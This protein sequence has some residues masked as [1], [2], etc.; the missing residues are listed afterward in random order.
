MKE[1]I[2]HINTFMME[3]AIKNILYGNTLT[4]IECEII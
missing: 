4:K 2:F 1:S 3:N